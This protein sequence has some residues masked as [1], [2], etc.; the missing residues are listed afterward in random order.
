M[1]FEW[2][3]DE[4]SIK[5]AL[6]TIAGQRVTM[7]LQPGNVLVVENSPTQTEEFQVAVRTAHIRGWVEVLWEGVPNA[8][9]SIQG[10][11]VELP[12]EFKPKTQYRLTEGGWNV[13]HGTHFWTLATFFVSLFAFFA[14]VVAVAVTWPK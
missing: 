10:A 1:F 14:S 8:Q 9:L 7:I 4:R 5:K 11:H 6:R 13:I 3:K 2:S 12:D